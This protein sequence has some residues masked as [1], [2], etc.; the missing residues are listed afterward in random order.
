MTPLSA[1]ASSCPVRPADLEIAVVTRRPRQ[2]PWSKRMAP[3]RPPALIDL[4]LL[5]GPG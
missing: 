5:A 4:C 1:T 3:R 2:L